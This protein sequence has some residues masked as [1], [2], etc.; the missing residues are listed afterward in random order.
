MYKIICKKNKYFNYSKVSSR[1]NGK[2]NGNEKKIYE[3]AAIFQI[4]T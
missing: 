1:K 2:I 4:K 3:M